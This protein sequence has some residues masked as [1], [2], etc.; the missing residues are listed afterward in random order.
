MISVGSEIYFS[1]VSGAL[2]VSKGMFQ[3]HVYLIIYL[4]VIKILSPYRLLI[5]FLAPLFT[6][7][8]VAT[9]ASQ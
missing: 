5:S 2:E 8:R 4:H 9:N 6:A 7:D 3:L 1:M